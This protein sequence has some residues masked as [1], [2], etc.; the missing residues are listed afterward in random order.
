MPTMP[1][2]PKDKVTAGSALFTTTGIELF[3]I[4]RDY[5]PWCTTSSSESPVH[6]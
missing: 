3:G 6:Y 4:I 2:Y 1:Q 5:L